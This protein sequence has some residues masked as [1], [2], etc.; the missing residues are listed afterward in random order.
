M[1]PATQVHLTKWNVAIKY[2]LMAKQVEKLKSK[3][4]WA[5]VNFRLS[6]K[7]IDITQKE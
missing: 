6:Y 5:W 4:N 7:V 2:V 3:D 1:V